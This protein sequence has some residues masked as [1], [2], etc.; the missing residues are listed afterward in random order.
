MKVFLT[1]CTPPTIMFCILLIKFLLIY[2]VIKRL[3]LFIDLT[4]VDFNNVLVG[5]NVFWLKF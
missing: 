4:R 1:K 3:V 2:L 5:S